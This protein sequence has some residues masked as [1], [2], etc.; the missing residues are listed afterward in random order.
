MQSK[1]LREK[2]LKQFSL[3]ITY[4]MPEKLCDMLTTIQKVY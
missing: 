4:F 3:R 2:D 1:D